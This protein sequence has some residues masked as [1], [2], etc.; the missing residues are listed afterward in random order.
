MLVLL[1]MLMLVSICFYIEFVFV[2]FESHP[3]SNV[4]RKFHV[5]PTPPGKLTR[6][7]ELT[8]ALFDLTSSDFL[9]IYLLKL[10]DLSVKTDFQ[11]LS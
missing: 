2:L 8:W 9:F 6:K 7:N 1:N 5:Y 11:T 4:E 3:H 10:G